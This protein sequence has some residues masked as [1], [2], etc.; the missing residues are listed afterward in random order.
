M[1]LSVVIIN[2]N[3]KHFLEQCLLS[4][5][6]ALEGLDAEIIVV[7]NQSKDHSLAYL[8]PVFT[9]VQFISNKENVGFAKAC[10]WCS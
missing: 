5:E 1:I 9:N 6:R 10:N 8:K 7:D 4:V 2:Y 3:V